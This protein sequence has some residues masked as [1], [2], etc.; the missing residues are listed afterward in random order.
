VT[1]P[2]GDYTIGPPR[3]SVDQSL[4]D[5]R[6]EDGRHGA[7]VLTVPAPAER[8][9]AQPE[10]VFDRYGK[11]S[12]LRAVELPDELGATMP[13]TRAEITAAREL[14]SHQQKAGHRAT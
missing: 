6:S 4:V 3:G 9:G 2:A 7:F 12:F 11:R 10:L 8:S 14:A 13:A 5:I 1:L